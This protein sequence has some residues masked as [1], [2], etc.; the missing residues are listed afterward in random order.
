MRDSNNSHKKDSIDSSN[1][2]DSDDSSGDFSQ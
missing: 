2:I 1:N